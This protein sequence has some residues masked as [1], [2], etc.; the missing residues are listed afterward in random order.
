MLSSD[1]PTETPARRRELQAIRKQ[2]GK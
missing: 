2:L 1:G